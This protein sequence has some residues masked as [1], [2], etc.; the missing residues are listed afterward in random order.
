MLDELIT[1]ARIVN[2]N[3]ETWGGA[4]DSFVIHLSWIAPFL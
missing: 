2:E 3:S 4:I 1:S